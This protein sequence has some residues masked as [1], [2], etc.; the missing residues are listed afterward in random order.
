MVLVV[1]TED[2]GSFRFGSNPNRH[3][4]DFR[5]FSIQKQ[6]FNNGVACTKARRLTFAMLMW[7]VRYPSAPRVF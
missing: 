7:W 4:V 1:S 5:I 6:K 2:C 3:P